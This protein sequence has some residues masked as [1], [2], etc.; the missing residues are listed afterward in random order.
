MPTVPIDLNT[1]NWEQ[2]LQNQNGGGSFIGTPFQRGG[3]RGKGLGS[4]L[5]TLFRLIPSFLKSPVG[6][7]MISS[8]KSVASDIIEGKS[9][10]GA[11]KEHGRQSVKNLTGLGRRKRIKSPLAIL[12]PTIRKHHLSQHVKAARR[13]V[14]KNTFA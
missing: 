4:V 2:L 9:L 11:I 5:A 3:Q 6:L 8:G 10:R 7:E 14:P 13:Q 12:K 1:V